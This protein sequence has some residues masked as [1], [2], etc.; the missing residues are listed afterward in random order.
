MQELLRE[1]LR[2]RRLHVA[3]TRA[4]INPSY[5]SEALEWAPQGLHRMIR[6]CRERARDPQSWCSKADIE[7]QGL[8]ILGNALTAYAFLNRGYPV[9]VEPRIRSVDDQ[10][11]PQLREGIVYDVAVHIEER[12][13]ILLLEVKTSF[14][15]AVPHFSQLGENLLLKPLLRKCGALVLGILLLPGAAPQKLNLPP[16]IVAVQARTRG[17]RDHEA[18]YTTVREKLRELGLNL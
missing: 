7:G 3:R 1:E 10:C 18:I 13:V 2:T 16:A 12:D 11:K 17:M 14:K 9:V 15:K 5:Y 8:G 6:R 4:S